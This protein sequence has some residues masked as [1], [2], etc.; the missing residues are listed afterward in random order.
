MA[1]YKFKTKPYRHQLEALKVLLRNRGGALFMDVGTGKSKTA[2]DWAAAESIRV[3]ERAPK[4]RALVACPLSVLGVWPEQIEQHDPFA[5]ND[6]MGV[7]WR[8]IHY[9]VVWRPSVYDELVE[10]LCEV[11]PEQRII[12]CDESHKI[13]THSARRSRAMHRLGTHTDK[14]VIMSGTAVTNKNLLDLFS[15]FRFLRESIFGSE[16]G[17][18][19]RMVAIYKWNSPV[20]LKFK[21]RRWVQKK[22]EHMVYRIKADECLDLPPR[23]HKIIPVQL[24]PK[25]REVYDTLAQQAIVEIENFEVEAAHVLTRMMR[26]SQI[27]GGWLKNEEGYRKISNAKIEVYED[28]LSNLKEYDRKKIVVYARFSKEIEELRKATKK[29]GYRVLTIRGA[30]RNRRERIFKCFKNVDVP[31]VLIVQLATGSEGRNELV[32]AREAI[33]FSHDRSMVHFHQALGRIHRPGQLH[34]VTYFHLLV[35]ESQDPLGLRALRENFK[36]AEM[37]LKYPKLLLS[38]ADTANLQEGK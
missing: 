30:N 33:F 3:D 17:T 37:A 16:Y 9:D 1:K 7:D 19:K 11:P 27:T 29:V 10:W 4:M 12:I 35:E 23:I 20:I 13:K 26:L 36:A 21:N 32:V 34:K 6:F 15:Q 28:I 14:K 24:E 2:I 31:T 38:S 22:T 18:F 25:A 8:I 5:D